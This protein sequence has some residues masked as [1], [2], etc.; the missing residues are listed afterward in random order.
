[1]LGELNDSGITKEEVR[2]GKV[3]DLDGCAIK[4]LK[5]GGVTVVEWLLRC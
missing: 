1:M 5:S 3:A 4:C 2:A